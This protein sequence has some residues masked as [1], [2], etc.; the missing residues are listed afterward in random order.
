MTF[1]A[2]RR[3]FV[4]VEKR[5]NE[6]GTLHSEI[7]FRCCFCDYRFLFAQ[8]K[9]KHNY[10]DMYKYLHC[11]YITIDTR[12]CVLFKVWFKLCTQFA[13]MQNGIVHFFPSATWAMQICN[14]IF[15]TVAVV[16]FLAR[17]MQQHYSLRKLDESDCE[18]NVVHFVRAFIYVIV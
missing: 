17:F 6:K 3:E 10:T 13:C 11:T 18:R 5:R 14:G 8:H 9:R 12:T 4:A 15:F 2:F 7:K 16:Y 1:F